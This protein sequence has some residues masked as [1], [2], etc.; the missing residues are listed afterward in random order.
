[1]FRFRKGR[2]ATQVVRPTFSETLESRVLLSVTHPAHIGA[3]HLISPD[4]VEH[5]NAQT[6]NI[7]ATFTFSGNPISSTSTQQVIQVTYT[8]NTSTA[9]II[10][11]SLPTSLL[12]TGPGGYAQQA[13]WQGPPNS[14]AGNTFTVFYNADAI[15]GGFAPGVYTVTVPAGQV[16]DSFGDSNA[17]ITATFTVSGAVAGAGLTATA[18]AP[19]ITSAL[20][21][22]IVTVTY[23]DAN[24]AV[25][26]SAVAP[27]NI[28][29][30]GP[31]GALGI[32]GASYRQNG[33]NVIA[34]YNV[35][36]PGGSWTIADNGTYTITVKA[37]SVFDGNN[38]GNSAATGTFSVDI[39]GSTVGPTVSL[40]F[41]PMVVTN[42]DQ[43][44]MVTVTYTVSSGVVDTA[45]I[46]SL[47]LVVADPNNVQVN[48]TL[49][50][51]Q[52][53]AATVKA[54]YL[55]NNPNQIGFWQPAD[56][57]T[58]TV[59]VPAGTVKDNTGNSNSAASGTFVVNVTALTM[60][61]ASVSFAPGIVQSPIDAEVITVVYASATALNTSK[62]TA[63]NVTVTTAGGQPLSVTVGTVTSGIDEVTV[64]YD[65]TAP[66]TG[67]VWGSADNGRYTVQVGAGSVT[68]ASG[69]GN[70]AVSGAGFSV[71][72]ADVSSRTPTIAA[73]DVVANTQQALVT[74]TFGT[75]TGVIDPTTITAAD[76]TVTSANGVKLAVA[77]QSTSS[78]GPAAVAIFTVAPPNGVWLQSDNET[79]AIA[80]PQNAVKDTEGNGNYVGFG[81]LTVAAPQVVAPF[82]VILAP[83]VAALNQ[84]AE[85]FNVVY[86]SNVQI[87]A[88]ASN[89]NNASV[90]SPSNVVQSAKQIGLSGSGTSALTVTSSAAAPSGSWQ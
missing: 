72:L 80:I 71:D 88:G 45:T 49:V 73:P 48:V 61:I 11:S 81:T 55:I 12:V 67:G 41:A 6:A 42:P 89:L 9:Q 78:N 34:T 31:A 69:M 7:T 29:V 60:P 90:T 14:I 23:S 19:N 16:M 37:N 4:A 22:E 75:P 82:D 39:M 15:G 87:N 5:A 64:A 51:K 62:I 32:S 53:A 26:G 56:N 57:T 47:N 33:N 18:S 27:S 28:T 83:P 40:S 1:M 63:S 70:A 36:A 25:N 52:P 59:T 20:Q 54:T 79:Y 10:E 2:L 50:S 17:K 86:V 8:D 3:E 68:D 85:V 46:T 66:E 58:Y 84:A 65:V 77:V 35:N 30:T 38:M 13:A 21:G 43:A 24:S 76:I 44:E 74:V